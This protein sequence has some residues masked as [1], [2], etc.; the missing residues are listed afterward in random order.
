VHHGAAGDFFY[1]LV[2][3]RRELAHEIMGKRRN[4]FPSVAQRGHRHLH[5]I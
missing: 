4:I 1:L 5:Y 2:M 3:N